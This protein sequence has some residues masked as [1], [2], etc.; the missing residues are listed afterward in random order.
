MGR[1]YV[2]VRSAPLNGMCPRNSG[3]P[4]Q[5]ASLGEA[6][7]RLKR[8]RERLARRPIDGILATLD[9]VIESWLDPASVWRKAAET[10]LPAATDLSPEMVRFALPFMLEPLQAPALTE[11]LDSELGDHRVLE[12]P[13]GPGLILHILSSNLPGLAAV[14]IA[15]SLATKSAALVKAGHGD[16]LF[17]KLFARSIG[18]IDADLGACIEACYWPGGDLEREG[19]ALSEADLVVAFGNDSTIANIRARRKGSFIGH[20]HR[21]SFALVGGEV[22]AETSAAE[23]AAHALALDVAIWDQR[24]CLSPQMCFIEGD[25]DAASHFGGL[26]A[27][28][29]Q[30]VAAWLPPGPASVGEQVAVRRFRQEAEWSGI[31]GRETRVFAASGL[32]EGTVVV[33]RHA[34]FRPTPLCRTLRVF[35]LRDTKEMSQL[36]EPARGVLEGAGLAVSAER[37]R[38]ATDLLLQAGVHRVSPLGQMQRPPLAWRQGGRPRV[39][40]WLD[41]S[42]NNAV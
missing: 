32:T 6:V 5:T 14:P 39:A 4:S 22:L 7:A 37:R 31:D 19:I 13:H 10:D 18:A 30:E 24:G 17:P 42:K 3:E 29:L 40:D 1:T 41:W 2:A 34:A 23:Q 8:A 21:V 12:K 35:P 36:L 28:A 16:R 25:L 11:L 15:L 38:A 33:E 20:G 9:Q 27:M 26:I